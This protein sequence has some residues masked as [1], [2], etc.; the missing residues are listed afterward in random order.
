MLRWYKCI[1]LYLEIC[2]LNILFKYVYNI[3]TC[4]SMFYIFI[5]V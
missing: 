3:Y 5:V 4:I 1:F 2:I